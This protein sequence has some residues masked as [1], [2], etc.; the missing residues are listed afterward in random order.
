[1]SYW[2]KREEEHIKKSIKDDAKLSHQIATN[3]R[4]TMNDIQ[5][6]IDAFYG[7]YATAEGIT[8]VEARKRANKLDI[9]A[10]AEKAAEYIK[11]VHSGNEDL[12]AQA[13]TEQANAEMA[14]YNLAMKVSRLELLKANINLD[15]IKMTS[16]EEHFLTDA[17]T[18]G[19]R[20]EYKRQS[21][22]LGMTVTA[23][24]ERFKQ[25]ANASFLNAT[26]SERLWSNQQALKAE[27]DIL[28]NRGIIQG[29]NPK[30]LSVD[31]RKKFDVSKADADRLLITEM[32]RIQLDIQADAYKQLDVDVYEYIAEP[33]ACKICAPLDGEVFDVKDM[34]VG[35]N[36]PLMHPRCRCSTAPAV[37]RAE[38]EA[39]LRRRGL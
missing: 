30:A 31:L 4:R 15:L 39:D 16:E 3:K 25:V 23:T 27:L 32:A 1:M 7:K 18:A 14:I 20:A 34:Q 35:R 26:W 12:A 6:Q 11:K 22:I 21:G 17:F 19:A 9:R 33:G 38:W 13:F 29:K 5:Q 8:M 2:R 24:E 10:Y 37:D 28:L 36:A